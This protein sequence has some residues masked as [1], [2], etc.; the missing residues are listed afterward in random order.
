MLL[1]FLVLAF[2]AFDER[3][4]N[5]GGFSW[6]DIPADDE[7]TASAVYIGTLALSLISAVAEPVLHDWIVKMLTH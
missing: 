1:S 3:V 5:K 7:M 6:R 2:L 4:L